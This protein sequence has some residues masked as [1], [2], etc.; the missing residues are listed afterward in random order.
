MPRVVL[1]KP[2]LDGHEAGVLLIARALRDAGFEVVYLGPRQ[3]PAAIAEAVIQEDADVLGLSI[4]TGGH[5]THS[6]RVLE[7]LR[8]NG[9]AD[10]PVVVG[11][12]IPPAAAEELRRVGVADVFGP[13]VSLEEASSRIGGLVERSGRRA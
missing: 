8:E 1:A 6:E 7:A 4:L 12:I 5:L 3:T 2:G 10:V 13:G 9:A 11:G